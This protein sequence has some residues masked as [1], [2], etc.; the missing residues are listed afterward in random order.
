MIFTLSSPQV[1]QQYPPVPSHAFPSASSQQHAPPPSAHPA[2]ELHESP[3]SS[4]AATPPT[5]HVAR[6]AAAYVYPCSSDT[7]PTAAARPTC[8]DGGG[9]VGGGGDGGGGDGGARSIVADPPAAVM[10]APMT[11]ASLRAAAAALRAACASSVIASAAR[12]GP[13]PIYTSQAA[14]QQGGVNPLASAARTYT[15]QAAIQQG[16]GSGRYSRGGTGGGAGHDAV[17]EESR[18]PTQLALE[19]RVQMLESQLE[20]MHSSS[21]PDRV[22]PAHHRYSEQQIPQG[23]YH[24]PALS[25][26]QEQRHP[27]QI[28]QGSPAGSAVAANDR[29]L[30]GVLRQLKSSRAAAL[31]ELQSSQERAWQSEREQMKGIMTDLRSWKQKNVARLSDLSLAEERALAE[32]HRAWPQQPAATTPPPPPRPIATPRAPTPTHETTISPPA[33]L[34]HQGGAGGGAAGRRSSGGDSDGRSLRELQRELESL[35]SSLSV[36]L[37]P[38]V[39]TPGRLRVA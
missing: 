1:N 8:G 3:S 30:Q 22:S 29:E 32:K 27:E 26:Q 7:P 19:Q 25:E 12:G 28:P 18:S 6:P 9:G 14:I 5:G 37:G 36:Y 4:A 24:A 16:G 38:G 23:D 35:K 10:A 39:A 13:L 21:S 34:H 11:A 17:G 31:E 33:P 20:Q 2:T 15:T